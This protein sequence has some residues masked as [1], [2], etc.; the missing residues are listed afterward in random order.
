MLSKIYFFCVSA[1]GLYEP[2]FTLG[3]KAQC[4]KTAI[5]RELIE[6]LTAEGFEPKTS[7]SRSIHVILRINYNPSIIKYIRRIRL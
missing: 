6:L 3:S 2:I 5:S 1:L 4:K 7:V